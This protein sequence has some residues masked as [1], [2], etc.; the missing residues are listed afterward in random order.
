VKE[1]FD[2]YDIHQ[3]PSSVALFT[4]NGYSLSLKTL[5]SVSLVAKRI[6][7]HKSSDTDTARTK[8]IAETPN[9][10]NKISG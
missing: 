2:Q 9:Y 8:D 1:I 7:E 4:T 3:S 5:I 10:L 6:A